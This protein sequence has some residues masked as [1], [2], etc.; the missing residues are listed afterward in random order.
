MEKRQINGI[1][2]FSQ[3]FDNTSSTRNGFFFKVTLVRLDF[4]RNA[5]NVLT[6]GYSNNLDIIK[7]HDIKKAQAK[8]IS[9]EL[10]QTQKKTS[11]F[12]FNPKD[13]ASC[14]KELLCKKTLSF[15]F[16]P[17]MT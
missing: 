14:L 17:V 12:W 1:E 9:L 2:H 11:P 3:V 16:T 5:V 8:K 10:L 13:I 7:D 6:G 4:P 15:N